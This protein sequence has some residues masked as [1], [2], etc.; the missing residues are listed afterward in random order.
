MK[1]YLG[2]SVYV[3][4]NG[5]MIRLTTENGLL[6]DPSNQIFLEPTVWKNL[7]EWVSK[8]KEEKTK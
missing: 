2:D 4:F 7:K 3:E 8:L 5:H 6:G 1:E